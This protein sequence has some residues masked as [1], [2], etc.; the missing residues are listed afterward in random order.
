[1]ISIAYPPHQFK[2]KTIKEKEYIFDECR[3][4]W[5]ILTPE[6]WVRQNFIQYLIQNKKYPQSCIAVER[7]IHIG[8]VKKRFDIVVFKQAKPWMII[9]CKEG[10]VNLTEKAL[11]QILNY[12]IALQ[13]DF[14]T[15]TNGHSTFAVQIKDRLFNWLHELPIYEQ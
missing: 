8:D 15:I 9:E 6:E 1:M 2:I 14:L 7:E 12:N 5:V 4:N 11:T 13:V 3:K 10:N